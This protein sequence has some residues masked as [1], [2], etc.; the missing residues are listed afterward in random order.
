M[1]NVSVANID[2]LAILGCEGRLVERE[3]VY[4]LRDA[5]TAQTEAPDCHP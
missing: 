3:S 1:L 5:V 2:E 4:K